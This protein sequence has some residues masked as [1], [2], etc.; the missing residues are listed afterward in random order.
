VLQPDDS[1]VAQRG[2]LVRHLVLPNRLA[3]TEEM[4]RFLAREVSTGTYLNV[5]AQY[6]PCYKAFD[7]P[8]LARSVN[9]QEYSEAID[10]AHQKGLFRLDERPSLSPKFILG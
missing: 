9:R 4:A 8:Q 7:I 6:H 2:L 5:M 3:G 1:G 10:L